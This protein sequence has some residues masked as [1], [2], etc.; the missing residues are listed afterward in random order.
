M[1]SRR[2]I[3]IVT[4]AALLPI[5][6]FL[7]APH[8]ETAEPL[9]PSSA[10]RS[11]LPSSSPP[12]AFSRPPASPSPK[13]TPAP[14]SARNPADHFA[15]LAPGPEAEGAFAAWA[16]HDPFAALAATLSPTASEFLASLQPVAAAAAARRDLN[17]LL[18]WLAADPDTRATA[19]VLVHAASVATREHPD[20]LPDGAFALLTELFAG[21]PPSPAR[22]TLWTGWLDRH[23]DAHPAAASAWLPPPT[24]FPGD[25]TDDGHPQNKTP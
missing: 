8:S 16:E 23:L 11:P 17:R 6:T 22:D 21:L 2:C 1:P 18:L 24:P 5:A 10:A 25:P 9:R 7:L 15:N 12:A 4:T 13:S 20:P 3:L 14:S 19:T